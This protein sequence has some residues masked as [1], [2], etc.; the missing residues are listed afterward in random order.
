M[1]R[2]YVGNL[3]YSITSEDLAEFFA[4][5]GTVIKAEVVRFRETNKSRGFGFIEM[6][7]EAETQEAKKLDKME[8]KNR[9]I[10]VREALP[11]GQHRENEL[12]SFFDF[13]NDNGSSLPDLNFTY[14]GKEF[15]ILRA[16]VNFID[17]PTE[18][19]VL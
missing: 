14:Q 4:P 19:P 2:L 16:S 7:S 15:R 13:I 18:Q 9:Q 6:G 10:L 5:A 3:D 17:K 12:K 1:N 11:P 8:L